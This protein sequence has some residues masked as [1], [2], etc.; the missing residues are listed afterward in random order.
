[1]S[2][3]S[4]ALVGSAV[5][6]VGALVALAAARDVRPPEPER[7]ELQVVRL[8][9]ARDA[10]GA[11]P[12]EA[13]AGTDPT[14]DAAPLGAARMASPQPAGAPAD[15]PT[16]V[17]GADPHVPSVR[18]AAD[19]NVRDED[20]ATPTPTRAASADETVPTLA[21]ADDVAPTATTPSQRDAPRAGDTT[22]A[23]TPADL[24]Q[25]GGSSAAGR[26]VAPAGSPAGGTGALAGPG[27]GSGRKAGSGTGTGTG[28]GSGD[29]MRAGDARAALLAH[30]RANTGR[31]YPRAARQRRSEGVADV[32]FCIDGAGAPL[33]VD[34]RR[35]SG[36]RLLDDA[37]IDCVVRGSAPLPARDLCVSVPIDFHLR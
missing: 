10:G 17:R 30:L 28:T 32:A 6:H 16:P 22:P 11:D 2:P 1:M 20:A 4:R 23:P 3:F 12:G 31:C 25:A 35:S 29:G 5:L 14:D 36:S 19:A 18:L 15:R 7:I 8:P 37:A 13:S 34:L 24:A 27:R 26:A 9:P 21:T 33:R